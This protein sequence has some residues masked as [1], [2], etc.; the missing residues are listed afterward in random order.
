[1]KEHVL[2]KQ[3]QQKGKKMCWIAEKVGMGTSML[4]QCLNGKKT[5]TKEKELLIIKLLK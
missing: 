2:K 1:M 4:S 5:L 3:I